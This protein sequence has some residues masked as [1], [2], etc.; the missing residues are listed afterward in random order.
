MTVGR[1]KDVVYLE[2]AE[3]IH[4]LTEQKMVCAWRE[5]KQTSIID[6]FDAPGNV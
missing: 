4:T 5:T 6:F 1:Q 3:N 2:I